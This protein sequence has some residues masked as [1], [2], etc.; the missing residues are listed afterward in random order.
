LVRKISITFITLA[1]S[2]PYNSTMHLLARFNSD[3]SR[4]CHNM[5]Y[6]LLHNISSY[7]LKTVEMISTF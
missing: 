1:G 3:F 7:A 6:L 4:D 2:V 5:V